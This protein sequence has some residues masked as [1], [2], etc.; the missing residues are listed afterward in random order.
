MPSIIARL[1]DASARLSEHDLWSYALVPILLAALN[2]TKINNLL[3]SDQDFHAGISFGVPL[4]VTDTWSFVSTPAIGGGVQFSGP[5]TLLGVGLFAF[6]LLLQGVLLAGYLGGL[7][8]GLRGDQPRF[9]ASVGEYWQRMLGFALLLLVLF[10]PPVL[11]TLASRSFGT[12]SLAPL[13]L[14]WLVGFFVLGYLLYPAPYLIVLH[15]AGLG[16]ALSW[17][18]SLATDGGAYLRYALGYALVVVGISIPAT[19]VV[20]NVPV[21]GILLGIVGLAPVG[22]VFDTATLVFVADLTDEPL[23]TSADD[24]D[25][26]PPVEWVETA[27]VE[28]KSDAEPGTA[29]G[30]PDEPSTDRSP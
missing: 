2:G 21:L 19:L 23:S 30:S 22:L 16:E 4:P 24:D 10:L 13:V 26:S 7:H 17:S 27:D 14:L 3:Q 15:D 5:A 11:F 20:A 25:D 28:T 12:R 9:G 18:V 1:R 29:D 6:G 8:R